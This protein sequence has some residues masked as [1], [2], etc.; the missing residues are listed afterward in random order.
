MSGIKREGEKER[1][2]KR[3]SQGSTPCVVSIRRV[4][5]VAQVEQLCRRSTRRYRRKSSQHRRDDRYGRGGAITSATVS[6]GETR[7]TLRGI[8]WTGK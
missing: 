1:E 6:S 4:L 7:E 2:K 3:D 8:G 5:V